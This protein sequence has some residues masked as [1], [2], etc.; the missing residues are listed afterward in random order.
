MSDEKDEDPGDWFSRQFGKAKEPAAPAPDES[1]APALE[2]WE[3]PPPAAPAAAGF[4]WGFGG[5]AAAE[6]AP[7]APVWPAEP[8]LSFAPPPPLFVAPDPPAPDAALWGAPPE[9][10]DPPTVAF[11]WESA[12]EP[13]AAEAPTELISTPVA[14]SDAGN[15]LD[16]LFGATSFKDYEGESVLAS[17]PFG[18]TPVSADGT[19]PPKPRKAPRAKGEPFPRNQLIVFW[20]AGSLVAVLA[21]VGLFLVG[22][23]LPALLGPAPAVAVSK[24]PTPA[25]TPTAT[26][27]AGPVAVGVHKWSELRGGECLSPFTT[28]WAETFTV[29]DCASP[30]PAQM[31]FRA[32]FP[33]TAAAAATPAPSV[34]AVPGGYPGLAALQ[35]QIN[36]LCTAP[37]V[38]NLAAAGAYTDVQFQASY[39]ANADEWKNGQHD[40]FCFVMRKSGDPLTASVATPPAA[41]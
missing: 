36:V 10:A 1:A 27:V 12:P 31:V 16:S 38:I 28:V 7:A 25:P 6:S 11:P 21:L 41:G 39:A 29:V 8:V 26:A 33:P 3:N 37:G 19:V 4:N 34:T 23:R 2:P 15:P 17:S 9:G 5:D 13:I 24:T 32:T 20:I 18:G 30:H 22:T 35:A 40:Y 14:E